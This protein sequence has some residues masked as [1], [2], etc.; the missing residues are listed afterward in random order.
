MTF[1]RRREELRNWP[2]SSRPYR[3]AGQCSNIGSSK[4]GACP[5]KESPGIGTGFQEEIHRLKFIAEFLKHPR[6]VA[7]V[8]PSSRFVER[9]IIQAAGIPHAK[10][11]AELGAGTGGT[12]RAIL[13]AMPPDA[14]LLSIEI[15]PELCACLSRIEDARLISHAGSAEWMSQI[16]ACY[17]LDRFDAV[18]SGLPFS[19]MSREVAVQLMRAIWRTLSPGGCFVA[20]QVSKRIVELGRPCFGPPHVETELLNLPPIRIYQWR[21]PL[22]ALW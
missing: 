2:R 14:R 7:S 5:E 18:I 20:Y 9:R 16:V 15:N 3:P 12:T 8:L 19:T 4:D 1:V 13:R 10:T 17:E 21:K 6:Q 22:E 11:I